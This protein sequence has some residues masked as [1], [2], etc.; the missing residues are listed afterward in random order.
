M[1]RR[2][3]RVGELL[4]SEIAD[5]LQRGLREPLGF[6]TVTAVEVSPDLKQAKI[7]YSVLGKEL[8]QQRAEGI[9]NRAAS[10]IG[11]E[12]AGKVQMR[13][14]PKLTFVQDHTA[15]SA[16]RIHQILEAIHDDENRS[17][18]KQRKNPSRNR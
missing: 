4:R 9:L 15:E 5:V 1:S 14:F 12:V 17:S 13:Y 10:Y 2:T 8:D 3:E 7:F 11:R 18:K 16:A 6:V